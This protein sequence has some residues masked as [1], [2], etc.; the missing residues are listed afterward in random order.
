M[1][2]EFETGIAQNGTRYIE[3]EAGSIEIGFTYTKEIRFDA[4]EQTKKMK[5]IGLEGHPSGKKIRT[6]TVTGKGKEFTA[7]D[8][9]KGEKMQRFYCDIE[10][11][12]I[13]DEE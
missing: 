5:R 8:P 4:R 1:T 13:Y 2:T 6:Y 3:A 9:M 12:I 11:Q 10:E 7:G